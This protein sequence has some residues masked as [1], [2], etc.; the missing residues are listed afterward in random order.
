MR[1][2][3]EHLSDRVLDAAGKIYLDFTFYDEFVADLQT[4]EDSID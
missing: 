3:F 2:Y 1:H 4:I